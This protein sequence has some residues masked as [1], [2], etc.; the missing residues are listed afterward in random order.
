M[1]AVQ[2]RVAVLETVV[3]EARQAEAEAKATAATD[4]EARAAMEAEVEARKAEDH[5][6]ERL[7]SRM[8]G[9]HWGSA[10]PTLV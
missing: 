1:G 7:Q 3:A 2:R 8:N 9:L 4:G 10:L 5:H 6:N